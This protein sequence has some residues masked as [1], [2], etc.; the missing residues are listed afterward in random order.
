[1]GKLIKI[2]KLQKN[3]AFNIS[4]PDAFSL[5]FF[6][7]PIIN[8]DQLGVISSGKKYEKTNFSFT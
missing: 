3:S 4:L 6:K 8:R 7:G 1:M 2:G 5:L